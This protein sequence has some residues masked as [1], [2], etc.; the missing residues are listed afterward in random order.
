LRPGLALRAALLP[1]PLALVAFFSGGVFLSFLA[2]AFYAVAAGGAYLLLG[3][4][5]HELKS[6][7]AQDKHEHLSEIS[8]YFQPIVALIEGKAKYLPVMAGQL[9]EV[10]KAT[11]AAALDIGNKFMDIVSRAR[12]QSSKA[13]GA[14]GRFS[15]EGSEDALVELSRKALSGVIESLRSVAD[16][17]RRTMKDIEAVMEAM[18]EVRRILGEIE[19]IADQT[20]LLALNAAIEAARAGEQ[21]RGFAVVADEVRKLSGRSTKAADDIGRLISR[22]DSEIRDIYTRTERSSED[23]VQRSARAETAVD[24][25]MRKVDAVM[26]KTREDLDALT[27]ETESLASDISAIVVSMQFQDIT[28]QR[29]DH[30]REPLLALQGEFEENRMRIREMGE[31]LKQWDQGNGKGWLE[32]FYTMESERDVLRETLYLD[33]KSGESATSEKR[34]NVEIF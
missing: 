7:H 9:G 32:E 21:G 24:E 18:G 12:A 23:S 3:R 22:M 4:Q 2:V 8:T 13:A 29:I 30:V 1:L 33:G 20:N 34:S 15:G 28:R 14:F 27:T 11:E 5:A 17:S 19:Y 26:G 25:A 31:R 6:I 16:L 10:V